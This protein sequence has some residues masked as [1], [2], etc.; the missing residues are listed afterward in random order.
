MDGQ[1]DKTGLYHYSNQGVASW[2]DFAKAINDGLGYT[3]AVQPCRTGEY[4]TKAKRP[5]YSVMDKT[6]VKETFGVDIP[7]W[8]ESLDVF[9]KNYIF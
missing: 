9:I 8:R 1:S 7:H 4:P 3:C 2:Y 5:A 6:K